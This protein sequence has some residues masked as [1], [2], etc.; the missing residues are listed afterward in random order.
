L[1]SLWLI[2][3]LG[4]NQ[5]CD[6]VVLSQDTNILNSFPKSHP[7]ISAARLLFAIDLILTYPLGL[8][9]CRDTIEKACFSS[10][11]YSCVRHFSITI[12]L[13]FTTSTVASLTCDLGV[14]MEIIGG[15][16]S[17]MLAFVVPAAFWIQVNRLDKNPLKMNEAI[18]HYVLIIF[19]FTLM[20]YTVGL[21]IYKAAMGNDG[22]KNCHW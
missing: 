9:V 17:S 4:R 18:V 2:S 13:V 5:V 16:S 10:R 1:L 15:I 22:Q 12:F 6:F 20:F 19:G 21:T 8:Y 11:P 7:V 14:L 3:C